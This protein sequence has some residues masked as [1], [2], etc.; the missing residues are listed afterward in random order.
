MWL[1]LTK[2]QMPTNPSHGEI[3]WFKTNNVQGFQTGTPELEKNI[4][5]HLFDPRSN[6]ENS[7]TIFLFGSFTQSEIDIMLDSIKLC[8]TAS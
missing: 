4:L 3:L 2:H 6:T 7:Y 5:L 8:L 1:L